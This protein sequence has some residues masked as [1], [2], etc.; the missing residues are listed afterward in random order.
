[1]LRSARISFAMP[2]LSVHVTHS[3]IVERICIKF[4]IGEGSSVEILELRFKSDDSGGEDWHVFLRVEM[5]GEESFARLQTLRQ[6][7]RIV[8]QCL[9]SLTCLLA[10]RP[11][12]RRLFCFIAGKFYFLNIL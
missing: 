4:A 10:S 6:R 11:A 1:M 9:R 7:T 8:T 12:V 5:A 3:R 2:C